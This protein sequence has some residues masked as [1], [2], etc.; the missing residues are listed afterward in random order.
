M[1]LLSPSTTTKE[2]QP[3]QSLLM[4]AGAKDDTL[5]HLYNAKSGVGIMIGKETGRFYSW[6]SATSIVL[7]VIRLEM[8]PHLNT[9]AT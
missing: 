4:V 1:I 6:V 9:H 8:I 3:S 5:K 2:L 7:Y